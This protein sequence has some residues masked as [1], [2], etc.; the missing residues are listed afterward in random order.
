MPK[1]KTMSK[2]AKKPVKKASG[3]KSLPPR[4]DLS[5]LV[6]APVDKR[7]ATALAA[8][9]KTAKAF[10]K[11]YEGKLAKLSAKS[12]GKAF[13]EYEALCEKLA[14]VGSY[15]SLDRQ[16]KLDDPAAGKAF[17]SYSEKANDIFSHVLFFR[18]EINR[19]PDK[20]IRAWMKDESVLRYK[21]VLEQIRIFRDYQLSDEV[22]KILHDR[23]VTGSDAWVRM[24][25]ETTARLRFPIGKKLLTE[26]EAFHLLLSRDE[27]KRKAAHQSI[28]KVFGDNIGAFSFIYNT[29]VKEKEI[30]DRQRGYTSAMA[31]RNLDNQVEDAVVDALVSAVKKSYPKLSHRYY[32]L[33][34]K[35]MGKKKLN[36]WDRNA[37]LPFAAEKKFTWQG[38]KDAVLSAYGEFH[39]EMK[40]IGQRFF[41]ENWIDAA[42]RAGKDS[43]AFSASTVPSV[44]PYILMNFKGGVDDVATLA[45]ELGH[46]VH[47]VLAG[48]QG[49]F[50]ADTPLTL[51]E[52]AS[53]FG[54]MLTFQSL[55]KA[56]K[57]PKAKKAMLAGKVEDMLNTVVRQIAFHDFEYQVHEARKAGELTPEDLAKIWMKVMKESL[58]PAFTFDEAY[59]NFWAYIPH[60][61]HTPFYVYAYA[62]GD[63]LVNALYAVYQDSEKRGDHGFAD[64]YMALLAA[65]GTARHDVL[66]KPFGLSAKDASFW[67][68]GLGVIESFIDQLEKAENIA[69]LSKSRSRQ[70][71]KKSSAR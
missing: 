48:K 49:Y 26:T 65:G 45:H 39:P 42:P 40:K 54:E 52:T 32:K 2:T 50:M 38:A 23:D 59:K 29:L 71:R 18:L 58:G 1:A 62:F 51:A 30:D 41:D 6:A 44:H 69:S 8:G 56:E 15:L 9:E 3:R 61:Y 66:L 12:F 7:V 68:K 43:G 64:K 63:C 19:L 21:P 25:D 27:K 35:W 24:F 31:S 67:Q 28:G 33:K 37:P 70:V 53:V 36:P 16:T 60:F 11:K 47:Q 46:G 57:N 4:W 20:T 5:H 17:Q 34:A 22:E 55:L 13:A 10:R 14:R